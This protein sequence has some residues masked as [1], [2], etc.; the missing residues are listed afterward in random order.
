MYI[1]ARWPRPCHDCNAQMDWCYLFANLFTCLQ[2]DSIN[3]A[4]YGVPSRRQLTPRFVQACL[5]ENYPNISSFQPQL[6]AHNFRVIQQSAAHPHFWSESPFRPAVGNS[7]PFP[8]ESPF[9]TIRQNCQP[10]IQV[11][12]LEQMY[13]MEIRSENWVSCRRL[14]CNN[15]AR[16]LQK[17]AACYDYQIIPTVITRT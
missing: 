13:E 5:F 6:V 17:I 11:E 7:P 8:N 9:Q 1:I 15:F 3:E 16:W 12:I 4:T 10:R 14:V 2:K